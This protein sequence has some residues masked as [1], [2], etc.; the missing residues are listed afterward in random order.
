MS[1]ETVERLAEAMRRLPELR[2]YVDDMP[3]LDRGF[4]LRLCD[5]MDRNELDFVSKK[6]IFWL[7]DLYERYCE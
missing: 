5:R 3:T 4:V 1:D 6:Q 2:D 7:R